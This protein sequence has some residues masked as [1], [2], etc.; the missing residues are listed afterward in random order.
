MRAEYVVEVEAKDRFG[1]VAVQDVRLIV[2]A[3]ATNIPI[4]REFNCN[5][6]EATGGLPTAGGS[7][8]AVRG[9]GLGSTATDFRVWGT[10]TVRG[11]EQRVDFES[12]VVVV[13]NTEFRCTSPEGFGSGFQVGVWA[14][15]QNALLG[16]EMTFFY[17]SPK[18]LSVS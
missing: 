9:T 10:R 6:T 14:Q 17:E 7:P 1:A 3:N 15:G 12:C 8:C 5:S 2:A 18:V 11:T 4:V 13:A 16:S